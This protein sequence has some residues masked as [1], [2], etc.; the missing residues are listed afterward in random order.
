L[1]TW[2]KI[3][4]ISLESSQKLTSAQRLKIGSQTCS[5]L[6]NLGIDV[7]IVEIE[8]VKTVLPSFFLLT[9]ASG[10]RRTCQEWLTEPEND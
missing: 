7:N 5:A 10:E 6:M 8:H 9:Q 3:L 1:K 4:R 2:D